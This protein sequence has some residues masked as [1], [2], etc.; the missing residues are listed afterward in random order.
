M[1]TL[2]ARLRNL[3]HERGCTLQEVSNGS[4]LTPSFL[5]RLERGIVN[6]SVGNLRKVA[7]FF[8]VPIT[9]FFTEELIPHGVV[10]RAGTRR[11]VEGAEGEIQ[12][13]SL[14]PAEAAHLLAE[15]IKIPP[16]RTGG[17]FR[18]TASRALFYVLSG[19]VRCR[20][21]S[22]VM[23]LLTGDVLYQRRSVALNW[24][25]GDSTAVV[26]LVSLHSEER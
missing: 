10:I 12:R 8:G 25:S 22:Q 18:T 26:L 4:G 15:I 23:Q 19:E 13:F 21:G 1:A 14:L 16:G 9:H 20:L 2:G 6:I 7:A 3:R 17:S 5:S 24:S 11:L